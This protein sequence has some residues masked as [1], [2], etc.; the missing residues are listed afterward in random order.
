MKFNIRLSLFRAWYSYVNRIDR[1]GEILFM[2][3][4]YSKPGHDIMLDKEDEGDRYPIQLYHHLAAEAEIK[5]KD[6]VEIGCGRGGGLSYICRYFLPASATGIDLDKQAIKFCNRHYSLEGLSFS[7]GD[8]QDL[9]LGDGCCDVVINLESSHRY[10]DMPGFLSEVN[11]ILRPG[12]YFLFAD[13]RYDHEMEGLK[14]ELEQSELMILK[15]S[16]INQQIVAALDMDDERRR[17]LVKKLAPKIF[18]KT[19]LN[20]AGTKGSETYKR[21]ISH[22]YIYFSYVLKKQL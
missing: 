8:A 20:F 19:A 13:F 15:E 22:R 2:N 4:G 5:N 7:Q 1:K 16:L 21:F 17:K 6:V 14:K 12:G 3:Y 18:Y 10:P 9:Q 11:R